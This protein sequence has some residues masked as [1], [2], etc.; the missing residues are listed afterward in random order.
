MTL[1]GRQIAIAAWIYDR[2]GDYA[3]AKDV[4]FLDDLELP[5]KILLARLQDA[6]DR[7]HPRSVNYFFAALGMFYEWESDWRHRDSE[8]SD[9]ARPLSEILVEYQARWTSGP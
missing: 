3:K 5:T 6:Y 4:M 9:G 7:F 1:T 8:R 2:F